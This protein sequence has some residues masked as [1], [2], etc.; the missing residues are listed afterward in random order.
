MNAGTIALNAE[1]GRVSSNTAPTTPPV[2]DATARRAV[3]RPWPRS[4]ARYPTAPATE[5]GTRPIVFETLAV[6]G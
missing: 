2:S 6:T 4:S 5:P 1:A 3:L